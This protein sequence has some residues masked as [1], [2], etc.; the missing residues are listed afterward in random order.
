[1]SSFRLGRYRSSQRM[2]IDDVDHV[3]ALLSTEQAQKDVSLMHI[4]DP[5]LHNQCIVH[6]SCDHLHLPEI[7]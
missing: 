1:M 7:W 4:Q 5:S 3:S 2:E 6:G